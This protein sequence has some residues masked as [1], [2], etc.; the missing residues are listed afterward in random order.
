MKN[1]KLYFA[2]F[3]IVLIAILGISLYVTIKSNQQLKADNEA[4]KS[5]LFNELNEQNKQFTLQTQEQFEAYF[6]R[7]DSIAKANGVTKH[8]TEVHSTEVRYKVDTVTDTIIK[9][10]NGF[11]T[12]D[13]DTNCFE[14]SGAIDVPTQHIELHSA[15]LN[16]EINT[17]Y[18][19][20][21][22]RVFGWKWTPRWGKKQYEV[23]TVSECTK[24]VKSTRIRIDKK[25]EKQ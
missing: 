14:L 24:D 18:Y 20:E 25:S 9:Q 10:G 5:N 8:I 6:P 1:I 21:R 16:D 17:F 12:F 3:I 11:F 23:K 2:L 19:Y 22:D 4:W 13:I 7:L 15:R